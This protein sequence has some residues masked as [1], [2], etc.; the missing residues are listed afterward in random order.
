MIKNTEE[1]F[2]ILKEEM[3]FEDNTSDSVKLYLDRW[4]RKAVVVSSG[5]LPYKDTS[6]F[7]IGGYGLMEDAL[8]AKYVLP[9]NYLLIPQ[10]V[11]EWIK[12]G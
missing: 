8:S 2:K 10:I 11:E 12:N 7:W 3:G 6:A 1:L 5:T 4:N 9:D